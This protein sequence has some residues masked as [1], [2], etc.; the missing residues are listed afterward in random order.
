MNM[1]AICDNCRDLR[2]DKNLIQFF[3]DAI[4]SKDPYTQGHSHHV[5]A[6]AEAIYDCLPY[7]TRSE[8]DKSKLLLAA[9]LHDIGKIKTLDSVLNKDGDLSESEWEI[10]KR[11]PKDG[12]DLIGNTVFGDIS[13]WILYHHER[14]DGKGYFGLREK[15]IP[16]ESRII[17]VADTFS[18]LRTYRIYRPAK[19]IDDVIDI[20]NDVKGS[21]LDPLIVD[22]FLSLGKSVLENLECNCRICRERRAAQQAALN[23]INM[24]DKQI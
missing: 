18:A 16:F 8:I 21:Q 1:T 14:L 22:S 17:A 2:K 4:E 9:L 7:K 15:A 11:H 19:P 23:I 13:D 24:P 6:I 12:A 10:M 20:L 3:I 5:R